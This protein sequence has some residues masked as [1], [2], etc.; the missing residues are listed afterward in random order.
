LEGKDV[1][2]DIVYFGGKLLRD[3][4]RC[5]RKRKFE[6]WNQAKKAARWARKQTGHCNITPYKCAICLC[7]HIGH[8]KR[9]PRE[10]AAV[11]S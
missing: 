1:T 7:F 11:A 2:A 6:T 9:V 3:Y 8:D 10:R 5:Y 4:F